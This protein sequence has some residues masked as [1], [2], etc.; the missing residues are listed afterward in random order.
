MTRWQPT[1]V[2]LLVAVLAWL[3][4]W[5][6][7]TIALPECA[8]TGGQQNNWL[9]PM[10]TDCSGTD[11]FRIVIRLLWT[12]PGV[13]SWREGI[14]LVVYTASALTNLLFVL[15]VIALLIGWNRWLPRLQWSVLVAA[16]LNTYW[17]FGM[18]GLKCGYYLWAVAF[19]LLF[20][21][22]ARRSDP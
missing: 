1:R 14:E 21:A 6:A 19:F 9:S 2:L 8:A 20:G 11:A 3:A 13:D 12:H 5:F 17:F 15:A 16:A 10:S 22:M 18:S 4:S 7:P